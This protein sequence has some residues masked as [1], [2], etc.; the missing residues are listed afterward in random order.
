[1]A[2]A[3]ANLAGNWGTA[4]LLQLVYMIVSVAMGLVPI[5]GAIA[6]L[7]LTGAL[8]V[9]WCGFFLHLSRKE[10][11]S[12]GQ[13]F[14]GFSRFGTSFLVML[15]T[16][17]FVFLWSLLLIIPGILAALSYSLAYWIVAD[18]PN[19][20][21]MDAIKR[22]KELMRGN[23]WKFF[24]LGWRFFGWALLCILTLGI[25]FLWL[26]AYQ[27]AS[28]AEFYQDVVKSSEA[29]PPAVPP[30]ANAPASA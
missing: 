1:M 9:G 3:R 12:V 20:G 2:T 22:S 18:D 24:C 26:G 6:Q 29:Q 8:V 11:I 23:R 14:D 25:G 19:I 16:G 5:V 4:V 30:S 13:L 15:L 10:P 21:A 7:L 17:I 28:F 27:G